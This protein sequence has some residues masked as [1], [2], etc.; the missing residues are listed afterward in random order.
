[1]AT[2][3]TAFRDGWGRVLRA[4][5][6]LGGVFLL[7][8]L[9]VVPF[10]LVLEQRIQASLGQ[11]LDAQTMAGGVNSEWWDR[12]SETATGLERTFSPTIIGFA[13][14]LDNM[15]RFLE[16]GRLPLA[17][18]GLGAAYLLGWVF[19]VGGI[20]DRYA[21]RR[22][23]RTRGFIAACGAYF[24]RFLRLGIVAGLGYAFLFWHVHG[25]LFRDLYGWAAKDLTA[26]RSAFV[27][28][29]AL[30][31]VFLG[32]AA[33]WNLVMDYAKV[34][35]VVEDRHSMLGAVLAAWRFVV[36]H[37]RQTGGLY[38]LNG[39]AFLLV[40]ALYGLA[41]PGAAGSGAAA[42]WAFA[43]GECYLLARL[44]VKLSFYASA[45]SLFQR[46]LAHVEYTA[47][48]ELLWPESPAAEAIVNAAPP[49]T[50][51]APGEVQPASWRRE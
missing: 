29:V 24:S 44:A 13:A 9:A 20:L 4:P 28:R 33:F 32:A 27:L 46:S 50:T 2:I 25:W 31:V 34:R 23:L 37:P 22:P 40:V 5:M 1:M 43:I 49:P 39:A 30:Y 18:I 26:E 41:A 12:F 17:L 45:T 51:S 7:T 16:N 42:W 6:V 21:R 19:L 48:P 15:S 14:V 8:L 47:A 10:G 38:L 36:G 35:A 11:S 3:L